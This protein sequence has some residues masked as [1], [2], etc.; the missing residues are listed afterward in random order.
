MLGKRAVGRNQTG[1][2]WRVCMKHVT[3]NQS[4]GAMVKQ[5]AE[6]RANWKLGQY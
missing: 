5:F 6:D 2:I 4:Y 3:G 1:M